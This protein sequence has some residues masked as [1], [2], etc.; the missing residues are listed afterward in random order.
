MRQN[1]QNQ[2]VTQALHL[3]ICAYKT[4]EIKWDFFFCVQ[5][6]PQKP[7]LGFWAEVLWYSVTCW[8]RELCRY[9]VWRN[10]LFFGCFWLDFNCQS[11]RLVNLRAIPSLGSLKILDKY[12]L[13]LLCVCLWWYLQRVVCRLCSLSNFLC[14]AQ[15]VCSRDGNLR[16]K[17]EEEAEEKGDVGLTLEVSLLLLR[18]RHLVM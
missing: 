5:I 15:E 1:D 3:I 8:Y 6:L 16:K 10:I 18:S 4:K 17:G 13:W 2:N 14:L 12:F 11:Y 7:E 9:I